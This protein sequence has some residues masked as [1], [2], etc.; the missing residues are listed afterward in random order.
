VGASGINGPIDLTGQKPF[1]IH[2]RSL[3]A[4][5]TYNYDLDNGMY[6]YVRL[7]LQHESEVELVSNVPSEL[8]REVNMV[9][10]SAGLNLDNGLS[11]QVYIRNLNN[12]K[13][14]LTA[15]P[16]PIQ[17][18]SFN[19]YPNQPRMFGVSVSYMFD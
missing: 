11:F 8:K 14:F 9:N 4:G 7:D 13:F 2:E 17:A 1:G 18:G 19:A 15:F 3:N 6:G 5:I 16:P 10:A 12:D